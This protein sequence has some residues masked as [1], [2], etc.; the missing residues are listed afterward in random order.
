MYAESLFEMIDAYVK[1]NDDIDPN[2]VI[3][4]GCS[5]GG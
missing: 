3:I 4:G 2:R 5:N 1:A